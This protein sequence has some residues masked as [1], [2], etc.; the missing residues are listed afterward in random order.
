MPYPGADTYCY[1]RLLMGCSVSPIHFVAFMNDFMQALQSKQNYKN[2]M[3]D[4]LIF[5][6]LVLPLTELRAVESTLSNDGNG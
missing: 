6:P 2:I 5:S 1:K 3:D 4:V